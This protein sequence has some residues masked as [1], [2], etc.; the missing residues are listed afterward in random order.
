[1]DMVK[2]IEQQQQKL[3]QLQQCNRTDEEKLTSIQ[4]VFSAPEGKGAAPDDNVTKV[5]IEWES[6][7]LAP[8]ADT[9]AT[10]PLG[11]SGDELETILSSAKSSS[12]REFVLDGG[13]PGPFSSSVSV[14]SSSAA[15]TTA[16]VPADFGD[17]LPPTLTAL[18]NKQFRLYRVHKR[19]GCSELGVLITKKFN[20]DKRTVGYVIAYI[21]PGGLIDADGR[22]HVGDELINVNGKVLRG[23]SMEEARDALQNAAATVDL[24]VARSPDFAL[25]S[26]S[27][28]QG[29]KPLLLRKRR[30]LPV[31]DRPK[32]APLSGELIGSLSCSKD[33][34]AGGGGGGGGEDSVLDVCD[35][36]NEQAAMK[37]V[38]K[39]RPSQASGSESPSERMRLSNSLSNIR[40]GRPERQLPELPHKVTSEQ[41]P[42]RRGRQVTATS[43][44]PPKG[45]RKGMNIQTVV[46][47]KGAGRKGLGFSVVGG[48]DS[49]RGSMGIFVKSIFPNGQAAEEGALQEGALIVVRCGKRKPIH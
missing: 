4:P 35:L 42:L 23:L 13:G 7:R 22:F 45:C 10:E 28:F 34:A 15:T 1:M 38:I 18:M 26:A 16:S 3:S 2:G 5:E 20:R 44:P 8:S 24:I 21:E 49:P 47:E 6:S 29:P 12:R 19:E 11:D 46:Y 33:M 27:A 17:S 32:S 37:T 40:A 25:Q 9:T 30:R 48:K 14:A 39:V 41:H 31:I 43:P 36:S